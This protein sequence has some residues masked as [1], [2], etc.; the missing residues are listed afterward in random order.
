[1]RM[2]LVMRFAYGFAVP[3]VQRV[4][5]GIL[6]MSGP[7]ALVLTTP[8]VTRGQ[9]LTTVADFDVRAGERIP[10]VLGWNPSHEFPEVA[11][12]PFAALGDT[13]D[14]WQDWAARC[15]YEGEWREQVVRSLLTLKALTYEPTGGIVAAPTTSLPEDLGGVRNWDYRYCWLR[16]A[17][18]TLEALVATGYQDEAL[19]F[20]SWAMRTAAG[21]PAQLQLMYGLA[22]ERRLPEEEL[23]WLAGYEGSRPVRIG[24]AAVEQFQL[25]V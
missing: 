3:W 2:D 7:D 11:T 19:A 21:D 18:L 24:N 1:M 6:A 12:D 25:D 10:F 9:G 20:R 5:G 22:G 14:F 23:P 15:T 4:D 8:V 17:A 13:L 16:D